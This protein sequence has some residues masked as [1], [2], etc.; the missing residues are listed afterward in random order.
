MRILWFCNTAANGIG[1]F[2]QNN[3]KGGWMQTL[4]IALQNEVDLHI[5]FFNPFGPDKFKYENTNY[6]SI[7]PKYW[8]LKLFV[9]SFFGIQ[10]N[11]DN[12]FK[13]YLSIV[14]NVKPDIIHVFG[15]ESDFIKI[16]EQINTPIIVSLQGILTSIERKYNGGLSNNELKRVIDGKYLI[17]TNFLPRTFAQKK[18]QISDHAKV[19]RKYLK[20]IKFVDGRTNWDK[21]VCKILAPNAKYFH[22]DRILRNSFY[23][24][25]WKFAGGELLKLHTTTNGNSFKGFCMLCEVLILLND[26]NIN[27]FCTVAGLDYNSPIVKFA[28]RKF[29]NSFPIANFKFLGRIE[30]SEILYNLLNSNIY[31]STS[32]IENS[33]NSVAE[34]MLVGLPVIATFAGGTE[35]YIKDGYN[36]ILIQEGDSYAM[37]GAILEIKNNDS[38][39]VFLG[40]NARYDSL[41]RHDKVKISSKMF[42]IYKQI[43]NDN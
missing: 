32:Y 38:L 42:D 39:A 16:V 26:L 25:E 5:A 37:A 21:R 40:Q 31:V 17:Y 14:Y 43:L 11:D 24:K 36:G 8:K 7:I 22:V 6:Y 23:E 28:R 9:K 15:T 10:I 29:G 18:K 3:T 41:K 27:Y 35:T 1:F 12:I 13:Q 4:N 30:E 2:K 20:Q 33:P 34:A 19:E